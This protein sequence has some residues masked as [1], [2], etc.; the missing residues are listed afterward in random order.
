MAAISSP[1]DRQPKR[2]QNFDF[3]FGKI[4]LL[5]VPERSV[6]HRWTSATLVQKC[7]IYVGVC[8]FSSLAQAVILH[9]LRD[10]QPVTFVPQEWLHVVVRPPAVGD[11]DCVVHDRLNVLHLAG[12]EPHKKPVETCNSLIIWYS[13][14]SDKSADLLDGHR[15]WNRTSK[16]SN[17]SMKWHVYQPLNVGQHINELVEVSCMRPGFWRMRLEWN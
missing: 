2:L 10:K 15:G 1:N 11:S 16:W 5:C 9:S 4:M 14:K 7:W 3:D 6:E 12:W 8:P 17:L 13:W